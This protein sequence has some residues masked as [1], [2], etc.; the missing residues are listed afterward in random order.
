MHAANLGI[1]GAHQ[2]SSTSF[3]GSI[4]ITIRLAIDRTGGWVSDTGDALAEWIGPFLADDDRR[5]DREKH[6]LGRIGAAHLPASP[7]VRRGAVR[8]GRPV[9]ARRRPAL[10]GR[11]VAAERGDARVGDRR[12]VERARDAVG[13]RL[14]LVVL[15]QALNAR[16]RRRLDELLDRV[17]HL[18]TGRPAVDCA[19][20]GCS[21]KP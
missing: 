13:A 7:H 9:A 17:K 1:V 14:G 4:Y 6:P 18:N 3:P 16:A 21:S 20:S 8:S 5:R 2:A 11:S 15:R 10:D 12:V 19:S